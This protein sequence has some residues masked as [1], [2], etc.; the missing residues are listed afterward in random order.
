MKNT[1]F[2]KSSLLTIALYIIAKYIDFKLTSKFEIW[3]LP[4]A[5]TFYFFIMGLQEVLIKEN[6]SFIRFLKCNKCIL[7]IIFS[8]ALFYSVFFKRFSS[9]FNLFLILFYFYLLY[10]VKKRKV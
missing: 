1:F 6:E 4:I 8:I 9:G 5:I 7:I 10:Y 3:D 2:L